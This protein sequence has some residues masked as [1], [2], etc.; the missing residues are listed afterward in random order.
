MSQNTTK[1]TL[2][3][4]LALAQKEHESPRLGDTTATSNDC[5]DPQLLA[6]S[7]DTAVQ[8][9]DVHAFSFTASGT[10]SAV[11]QGKDLSTVSDNSA[12]AESG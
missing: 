12:L 2:L 11:S 6:L 8:E 10:N 3:E 1:Q 4:Y 9:G 7:H 5:I